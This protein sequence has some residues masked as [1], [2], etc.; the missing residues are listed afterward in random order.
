[1]RKK[2][3]DWILKRYQ[4]RYAEGVGE[5][6]AYVPW[7]DVGDVPSRGVSTRFKGRKTDRM[8]TAL[9]NME[10]GAILAAQ[11][12]DGV[13]DIREQFPLWPLD[14]TLAIAEDLGVRHP[15][16]KGM[17]ILMTTDML[18]TTVTGSATA[19][20][21][22]T[23]KP[24]TELGNDRVLEKFEI[25]RMYWEARG[26]KLGIVTE[27]DLPKDL[28]SNL[29]W[30][31]EF[32]EISRETLSAAAV[33]RAEAHLFGF[34]QENPNTAL[35]ELCAHADDRLGHRDGTCLGVVRHAISRKRWAVSLDVRID[36][37]RP[38][39]RLERREV[40]FG[41]GRGGSCP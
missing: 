22:I 6:A 27:R 17:P 12:L 40:P 36:P 13:T 34:L 29:L 21:P 9:S 16:D 26:A 35:N 11:W 38:L 5:L 33:G 15:S 41:K 31:D 25:E 18:L 24:E 37:G 2:N 39:P 4:D 19:S 1:M 3:P 8:H 30:L 20:E 7:L 14:K 23:V 32:H 10:H 28:V